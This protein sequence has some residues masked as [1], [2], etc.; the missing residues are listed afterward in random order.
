MRLKPE[1]P[2]KLAN[3]VSAEYT[4]MRQMLLPGL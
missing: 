3:P 2:I 1:N 4:I